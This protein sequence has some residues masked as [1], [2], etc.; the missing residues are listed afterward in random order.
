MAWVVLLEIEL[1][2]TDSMLTG[3]EDTDVVEV[4]VLI[5]DE[6]VVD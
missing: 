2:G 6:L 5:I 3:V 1:E 4:A